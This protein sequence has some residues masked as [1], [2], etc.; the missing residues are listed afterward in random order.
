MK[1]NDEQRDIAEINEL[2]RELQELA[3]GALDRAVRIGELLSKAKSRAPHG[4]WLSWL[5]ANVA[6]SERTAR[7]YMRVFENQDK[8]KSANVAD[9]AEAY[10]MLILNTDST[11]MTRAEAAWV[12]KRIIRTIDEIGDMLFKLCQLHRTHPE[13]SNLFPET[14]A[15]L[16]SLN[17]SRTNDEFLHIMLC[18]IL[19]IAGLAGEADRLAD[20]TTTNS[21]GERE[22]ACNAPEKVNLNS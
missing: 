5:A 2:H 1:N 15:I 6:F 4:Q 12:H 13:L 10:Q 18:Q 17:K 19:R 7:N 16:E 14:A 9:L 20:F 21:G 8:L 11:P 22:D 3:I